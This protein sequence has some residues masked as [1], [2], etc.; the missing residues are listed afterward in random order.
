MSNFQGVIHCGLEGGGTPTI[1]PPAH[2]TSDCFTLQSYHM[3]YHKVPYGKTVVML[4]YLMVHKDMLYNLTG[5]NY[6]VKPCVSYRWAAAHQ[7][8]FAGHNGTEYL[9]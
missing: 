5:Y 7:P 4:Y 3:V 8:A 1:V 9:T 6:M 2:A